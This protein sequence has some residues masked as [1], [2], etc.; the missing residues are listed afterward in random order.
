MGIL[1][2]LTSMKNV[3]TET[4]ADD[5]SVTLS[6]EQLKKLQKTLLEMF[7]DIYAVCK[8]HKIPV[9]FIAGSALGAVRHQGFIPWDDDLDLSM[10]RAAYRRFQK[11]FEKELSDK[12]ILNAPNYGGDAKARFA[13]IQKKDTVFE[14]I[15]DSRD[16]EKCKI[17]VD[18]FVLDNVPDN[19]LFK[20]LKGVTCNALEF[21]SNTVFFYENA[22]VYAREYYKR[23]GKTGYYL[24]MILGRIFSFR[25]SARWFDLIDK[26][27]R[28]PG[29]TKCICTPTGRKHYFGEIYEKN[30]LFPL[31]EIEF[32]GVM[33]PVYKDMDYYLTSLYGDYM[34]IPP[35]E[36][37]EKHRLKRIAFEKED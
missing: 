32:E 10:P 18:L 8:K 17:F 1:K 29:K 26:C 16:K 5:L 34:T 21:I 37:R 4:E 7:C 22:D 23:A 15:L 11:V 25:S 2:Q 9:A 13:K 30:R 31:Q 28:H 12:Y 27:V 19:L 14:E 35:V 24:R 6:D 20:T 33:V 36:K 3:L